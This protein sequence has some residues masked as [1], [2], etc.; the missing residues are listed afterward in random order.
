MIL[1]SNRKKDPLDKYNSSTYILIGI[2]RAISFFLGLQE[3]NISDIAILY[4]SF[5]VK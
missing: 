1:T 4:I 5:L 3:I 2:K